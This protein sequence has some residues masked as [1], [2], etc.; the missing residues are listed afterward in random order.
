MEL[1]TLH[2]TC[3]VCPRGCLLTIEI[4]D[5]RIAVSGNAC[6]KG[7]DYGV[8]EAVQPRRILTTTVRT[9]LAARP[10]LPVRTSAPVPL[11]EFRSLMGSINAM[12]AA[13]PLGCGDVIESDLLGLGVDLIATDTLE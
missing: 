10:R 4:D 5:A 2:R 6:A 8:E 7:E 13:P 3:T 12:I 1:R 11:G 9:T